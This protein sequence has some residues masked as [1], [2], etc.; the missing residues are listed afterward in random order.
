VDRVVKKSPPVSG[1][2][3]AM[4][5]SIPQPGLVELSDSELARHLRDPERHDSAL[6][7]LVHRYQAMVRAVARRYQLP[8]QHY[9]DLTQAGY[10]GLMKA[11]NS[12]DPTIWPELKPYA[13]ACV[14]GEIKRYFRDKRWLIRVGRADQELL[15]AAKKA[16]SDLVAEVGRTP[17]DDEVAARLNVTT[18]KLQHAYLAHQAFAPGSIDA[19]V[20]G[21]DEREIS[22]VIGAEDPR[23]AHSDAMD[24]VQQHWK[25]LPANQREVLL[26]RFYGNMTQAQV[27]DRLHCS[28][29]HVSR[30]QS[31]AL[32]FLR[33]R[34]QAG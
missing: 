20:S 21:N 29:M 18:E 8:A 6:E 11:I 25:E 30:L 9:E 13:R 27:A 1:Q 26:M 19:P 4:V 28:Q 2:E 10:V 5:Y 7:M 22:E 33:K 3:M 32:A 16:E 12:F 23:L 15:L 31:R 17:T 24:A 34:L 14:D